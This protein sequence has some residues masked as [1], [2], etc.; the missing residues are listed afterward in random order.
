MKKVLLLTL[1]SL[2]F[3][4]S[5]EAKKDD[6]Y[7]DVSKT[8]ILGIWKSSNETISLND[9]GEY[10]YTKSYDYKNQPCLEIYK[11]I[12]KVKNEK[13]INNTKTGTLVLFI[14]GTGYEILIDYTLSEKTLSTTRHIDNLFQEW[15]FK[16]Q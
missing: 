12:F 2:P 4:L 10:Y 13:T 16:R 3:F 6:T 11:G 15:N 14:E 9:K 5:C 8:P 1:L 7:N